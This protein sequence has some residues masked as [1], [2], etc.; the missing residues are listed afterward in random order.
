MA[1]AHGRALVSNRPVLAHIPDLPLPSWEAPT[2]SYVDGDRPMIGLSEAEERSG[3][4]VSRFHELSPR[5]EQV[6]RAVM[7]GPQCSSSDD[8][9]PAAALGDA[10]SRRWPRRTAPQTHSAGGA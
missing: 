7:D 5:E 2:G 9:E 8:A 1:A 10:L 4:L 3:A 6:L